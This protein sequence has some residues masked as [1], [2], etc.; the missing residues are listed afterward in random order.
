MAATD[1]L[2]ARLPLNV[3]EW[4]VKNTSGA[5]MVTGQLVKVDTA[6][7][8]SATQPVVGVVLTSAATD[9]PFGFI[10]ENIPA[11][12]IGR[13]QVADG[14]G[15]SGIAAGAIAVGAIVGASAATP[16]DVTT[17]TAADPSIGQALTAAVNA[18][19]PVLIQIN[20]SK[21]A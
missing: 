9:M 5:A 2:Y 1:F 11:G 14:S 13:C 17:A 16:G 10:I 15:V 4:L 20:K 18:G 6:N 21:N 8:M 3:A 12:G 19:D 7:P